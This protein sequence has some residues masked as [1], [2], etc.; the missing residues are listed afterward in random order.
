MMLMARGEGPRG[1][2]R[3]R[4]QR[5]A[6]RRS[7]PG[8]AVYPVRTLP[9]AVAIGGD[10][11]CARSRRAPLPASAAGRARAPDLADVRG[12]ALARRALE[13]AAAGGHNLLLVGPPGAG[14]TMLARRL[15]GILPPLSEAEALE[16]TAI[17][18]AWGLRPDGL[19]RGRPFRG[20]APHQQ[21]RRPR[22]RRCPA[23]A[24]RGQPRPQRR[25]LPRRA[26]RVPA[27]DARGAAPAARGALGHRRPRAC[28]PAPAGPLPARRGHEPVPL[29]LAR[30]PG[31]GVYVH[32]DGGP[33]V[34]GADLG[35]AARPDRPAGRGPHA[36]PTRRSRPRRASRRPRSRGAS[37]TP[38][39][40]NSSGHNQI[41]S[42]TRTCL[43]R[44]CGRL[45]RSTR[46]VA[47]WPRGR[48][49]RWA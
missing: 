14:K 25:P 45:R 39:G 46:R 8:S 5:G 11:A 42:P 49:T 12:Q 44:G 20:A 31:A 40:D 38:G 30:R 7:C 47:R 2:D 24:G 28:D 36:R 3:A 29:R 15:P 43:R 13:I 10:R 37:R 35:A 23:A 16:T 48:S 6:R 19:L 26:A 34:P 32:A 27:P 21:R 1:R 17:H 4:R 41:A 9:E 22:R 33:A 18:S